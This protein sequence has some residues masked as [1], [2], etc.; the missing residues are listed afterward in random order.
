MRKSK[1]SFESGDEIL[2][3]ISKECEFTF[4][5]LTKCINKSIETGYIPDSLKLATVVPV[6]LKKD[7]LDKYNYWSVSILPWLSKVSEKVNL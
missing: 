4:D 1:S 6:Y 2:T 7:P 5:V 3:R